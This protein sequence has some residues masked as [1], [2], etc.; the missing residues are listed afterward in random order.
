LLIDGSEVSAPRREQVSLKELRDRGLGTLLQAI[1]QRGGPQQAAQ[2][3]GIA[4]SMCAAWHIR[5]RFRTLQ[6]AMSWQKH[7]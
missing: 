1:Y 4:C 2:R 3:L 7:S 6:L 5:M